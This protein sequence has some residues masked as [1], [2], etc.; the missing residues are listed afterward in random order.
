M[1][2]LSDG[3]EASGEYDRDGGR[4]HGVF[5]ECGEVG[6]GGPRE[7]VDGRFGK[8]VLEVL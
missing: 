7:Q 6:V 1:L 8:S 5:V 4:V 3:G 2:F